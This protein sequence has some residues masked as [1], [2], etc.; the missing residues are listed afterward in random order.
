MKSKMLTVMAW[1]MI[2]ASLAAMSSLASA[3]VQDQASP[4]LKEALLTSTIDAVKTIGRPGGYFDNAAIKI[5]LSQQLKP[6]ET[7]LRT[8][9]YGP[10]IES[11]C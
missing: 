2:P 10:Q 9:G 7:G 3:I 5:L 6:V 1:L 8:I 4:G 11:W